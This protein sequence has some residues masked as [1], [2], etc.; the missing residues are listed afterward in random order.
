M[1][2]HPEGEIARLDRVIHERLAAAGP[3]DPAQFD[4]RVLRDVFALAERWRS[5]LRADAAAPEAPPAAPGAP[6]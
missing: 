6:R 2:D 4:Q 1:R 3:F 5:A